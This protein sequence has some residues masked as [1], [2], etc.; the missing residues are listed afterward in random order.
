MRVY[1]LIYVN[2][3]TQCFPSRLFRSATLFVLHVE[4]L[5]TELRAKGPLTFI[6]SCDALTKHY[7]ESGHAPIRTIL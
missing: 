1:P 7:R 6:P 4:A 5:P 3:R 2:A